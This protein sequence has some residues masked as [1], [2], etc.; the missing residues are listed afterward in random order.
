MN[1]RDIFSA[2]LVVLRM[3]FQGRVEGEDQIF[4]DYKKFIQ[5]LRNLAN[6]GSTDTKWVQF[7]LHQDGWEEVAFVLSTEV[8]DSKLSTFC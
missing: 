7:S 4:F 5:H 6:D 8:V 1:I 2:I 3:E